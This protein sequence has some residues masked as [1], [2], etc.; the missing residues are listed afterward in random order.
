MVH[1]AAPMILQQYDEQLRLHGSTKGSVA[2]MPLWKHWYLKFHNTPAGSAAVR[3][4][5]Q[6]EVLYPHDSKVRSAALRDLQ[7]P[8]RLQLHHSVESA[9]PRAL[10]RELLYRNARISIRKLY[11]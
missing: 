1:C 10:L 6:P 9:A 8:K 7:R 11:A 5:H 2:E 4:L 3:A